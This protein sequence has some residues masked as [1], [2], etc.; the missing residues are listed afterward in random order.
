[1][2]IWQW[3]I[4]DSDLLAKMG[5]LGFELEHEATLNPFWGTNGFVN[6]AFVFEHR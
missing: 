3:G 4:T 1:M 5:A 2:H 6:K